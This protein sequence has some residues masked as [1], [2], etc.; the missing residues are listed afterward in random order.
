MTSAPDPD[1]SFMSAFPA[2]TQEAWRAAVDKVL[3]G[4]DFEKR[5]VGHTADGIR[6][7]PLYAAASPSARPLRGEAGRWQVATRLDHPDP[8]EAQKLALA[9]LEGGANA[10]TIA[11]A[12]ARAARGYGL[13]AEDVA[14]LDAALD[15]A[16]LDL[17]QLRL[18]PAPEGRVNALLLAAL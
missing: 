1:L 15:N 5:L 7:E 6:I 13:V 12:G 14:A 10:L 4:G 16:M 17:I 9:D 3:K 11:F 2:P 18:D 8:A